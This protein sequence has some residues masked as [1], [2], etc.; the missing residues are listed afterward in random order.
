LLKFLEATRLEGVN[1][2]PF[3]VDG[4]VRFLIIKNKLDLPMTGAQSCSRDA[5]SKAKKKM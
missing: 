1:K 2:L 4:V 3:L 5:V